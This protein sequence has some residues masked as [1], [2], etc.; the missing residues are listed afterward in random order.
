MQPPTGSGLQQVFC[1]AAPRHSCPAGSGAM[2]AADPPPV[3]QVFDVGS[4]A[5]AV[6]AIGVL[7][8][9]M[10]NSPSAK[11]GTTPVQLGLGFFTLRGAL[12][13]SSSS[14]GRCRARRARVLAGGV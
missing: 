5:I 14:W 3:L 12:G 6:H 9:I 13:Q 7:T 8:A 2:P 11:V 1:G 4:D 10:S